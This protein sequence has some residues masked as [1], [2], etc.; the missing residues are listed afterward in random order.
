MGSWWHDQAGRYPLLTP[1]Q[2]I[3]LGQAIRAWLD[4]PPPPPVA[5]ERT[6]KRARER[7]IR[8]N[9]RLVINVAERYRSAA[10]NGMDDLTQAGNEGLIRAV[11]KFD[12]SKGY[13]F[14]TYA[15]WWIWQ[16]ISSHLQQGKG[17]KIP[18]TH[19]RQFAQIQEAIRTLKSQLR[20]TPSTS[21]IAQHLGWAVATVE[22]VLAT[23]QVTC[24]LDE[25]V[26]WL[27]DAG[28]LSEVIADPDSIETLQGLEWQALQ[29]QIE[30]LPGTTQR[31]IEGWY[32]SGDRP[33]LAALARQE[34]MTRAAVRQQLAYGLALLR[35]SMAPGSVIAAPPLQQNAAAIQH[36]EQLA[37]PLGG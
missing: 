10:G 28:T 17:I 7:F 12:P 25:A 5:V 30:A 3:Q 19:N 33:P 8:C 35:Q 4:H 34:G 32:F 11:E 13:R 2:E 22:R 9:L 18:T 31:I 27:D 37:L 20:R 15:H 14:S 23:P 21:E 36:M 26:P 6:G 16:A 29:E 1:A 24:S